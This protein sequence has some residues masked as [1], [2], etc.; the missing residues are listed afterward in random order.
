MLAVRLEIP[1][2][3]PGAEGKTRL[4]GWKFEKRQQSKLPES[5]L[6]E[7]EREVRLGAGEAMLPVS[8][9]FIVR[10]ELREPGTEAM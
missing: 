2:S 1:A 4:E 8:K 6:L 7:S 3:V 9:L 5:P 10:G